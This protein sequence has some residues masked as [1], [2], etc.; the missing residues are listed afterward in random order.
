VRCIQIHADCD[1]CFDRI[2]LAVLHLLLGFVVQN[3][4]LQF[5][6]R[7]KP[8]KLLKIRR[9]KICLSPKSIDCINQKHEIKR[10]T[11]AEIACVTQIVKQMNHE[12]A[13]ISSPVAVQGC[14]NRYFKPQSV[15]VKRSLSLHN[16]LYFSLQTITDDRLPR[17]RSLEKNSS[18]KFS[19]TP[20][21]SAGF[22]SSTSTFYHHFFA[23][24]LR[25]VSRR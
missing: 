17:A 6:T 12:L 11:K 20:S 3:L 4:L 25:G 13:V 10:E 7:R 1:C 19:Q 9:Q 16:V 14:R 23:Q 2:L 5:K 18:F 21:L 15:P 24:F 22:S 8:S